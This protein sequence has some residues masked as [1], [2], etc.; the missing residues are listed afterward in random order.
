MSLSVRERTGRSL[1]Q[2]REGLQRRAG[3]HRG[4]QDISRGLAAPL[5][6]GRCL[7]AS[8]TQ[9]GRLAAVREEA[10]T[11]MRSDDG[12]MLVIS[13][14]RRACREYLLTGLADCVPVWLIDEQEPTWQLGHIAG[15][16]VVS[17]LDHARM[18]PDEDGLFEAAAEVART[19][20]IR[21][22][23]TYDEA[24]V[25]AAARIAERLGLPGL[26]VAGAE[27]CR[28]KHLTRAALT[29]SGL[30]QPRYALAGRSARPPPPR[31][32]SAS[33]WCSSRAAWERAPA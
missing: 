20:L 24:F 33:P 17:L 27:R 28:D 15:S 7:R 14:G 16:S 26:T 11:S 30:P 6:S 18:V 29:S 1:I 31:S 5:P 22:I 4:H 25:I 10:E 12:V 19:Q 23:C 8:V 13:S 2:M 9:R 32:A 3:N 21:G